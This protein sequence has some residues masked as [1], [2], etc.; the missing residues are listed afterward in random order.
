MRLIVGVQHL[1]RQQNATQP[2]I[3][4]TRLFDNGKFIVLLQS[5][6]QSRLLMHSTEIHVDKTFKRTKCQ[7]FEVNGYDPA[8]RRLTTLA[9]VF[10]DSEDEWS[11]CQAFLAMCDTA[12]KDEGHLV[13][14]GHL[15]TDERSLTGTRIK[16]ILVDL[17]GGQIRGLDSYFNLKYPKDEPNYHIRKIVKTCRVHY[18]R[19]IKNLLK[20]SSD[21]THEGM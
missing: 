11:Y 18:N 9:R 8:S 14:F 1:M 16:A 7:E 2:Y 15:I 3:R 19:A 21:T 20:K 4:Q 17:H 10:M 5:H 12:E 6:E 13:P